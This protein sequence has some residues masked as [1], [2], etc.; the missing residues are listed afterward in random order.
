MVVA[1]VLSS[2]C[3]CGPVMKRGTITG[4]PEQ[5]CS[6]PREEPREDHGKLLSN[7]CWAVQGFKHTVMD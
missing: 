6:K 3:C 5:K 2:L 1:A 7:V 4:V